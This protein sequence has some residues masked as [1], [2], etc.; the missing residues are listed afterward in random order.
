M[1][2]L[3]TARC[4][5]GISFMQV[6]TAAQYIVLGVSNGAKLI[7]STV[8]NSNNSILLVDFTANFDV[9]KSIITGEV[10]HRSLSAQNFRIQGL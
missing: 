1:S 5:F 2:I 9:N 6:D 7:L 4:K 8:F 10:L 3:A